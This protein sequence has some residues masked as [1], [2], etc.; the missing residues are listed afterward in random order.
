MWESE[1]TAVNTNKPLNRGS[2]NVNRLQ[3]VKHVKQES[4]DHMTHIVDYLLNRG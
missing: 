3:L 4:Q 2:P 1:N